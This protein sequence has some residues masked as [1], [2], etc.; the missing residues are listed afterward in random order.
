MLP[1][2]ARKRV[3]LLLY[4]ILPSCCH[5]CS[6]DASKSCRCCFADANVDV[7]IVLLKVEKLLLLLMSSLCSR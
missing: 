2:A 5:C 7:A 3:P 6:A 1:K 4:P